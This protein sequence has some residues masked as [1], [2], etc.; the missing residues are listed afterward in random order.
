MSTGRI[1]LEITPE[2]LAQ[3]QG[4]L[5][6]IETLLPGLVALTDDERHSLVRLGDKNLAHVQRAYA[7]AGQTP[8]FLP[9]WVE[10]N[11]WQ[12]DINTVHHGEDIL[13]PIYQLTQKIEDSIRLAGDEAFA[14]ARAYYQNVKV[15]NKDG[16]TDAKPIFDDLATRFPGGRRATT[17][18]TPEPVPATT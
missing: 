8:K 15:A 4:H 11:E 13:R 18:P 7:H 6:A 2:T 5:Q 14:A 16:V 1:S 12:K 17:Q 10:M 9:P 3:I